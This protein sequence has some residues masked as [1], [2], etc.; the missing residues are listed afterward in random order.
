MGFPFFPLGL[1]VL[2]EIAMSDERRSRD[3]ILADLERLS[4]GSSSLRG[5]NP[6]S[7]YSSPSSAGSNQNNRPYS[8]NRMNRSEADDFGPAGFWRRLV[9][10]SIDSSI[11]AALSFFVVFPLALQAPVL[12]LIL[13]GA[14]LQGV[15]LGFAL[16]LGSVMLY[17]LIV[18]GCDRMLGSTPGKLLVGARVVDSEYSG[19]AS[20]WQF[21]FRET[22]GK[23]LSG[24]F[25]CL[26]YLMV[27]L[28][29]DK[30][31]LHDLLFSTR[32]KQTVPELGPVRW[33]IGICL[34]SGSLILA[35]MDYDSTRSALKEVDL[36]P[37]TSFELRRI[38]QSSDARGVIVSF[39]GPYCGPCRKQ[40]PRLLQ[41]RKD[42]A[43][44]GLDVIFVGVEGDSDKSEM[45]RFLSR[46]NVDFKTYFRDE[47][48]DEF[49]RGT[50]AA[51]SGA[52]PFT[53]VYDSSRK[54][55]YEGAGS[56]SDQQ[57]ESLIGQ[58]IETD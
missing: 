25:L 30:L 6:H 40:F 31:A 3:E 51:W 16:A 39:W 10:M 35:A 50:S 43:D 5:G 22:L 34:V 2:G 33:G 38:V 44:R 18:F 57:L 29:D 14:A 56:L 45:A 37:V 52:I 49:I 53:M 48:S 28:R 41:L 12:M 55:I 27:A 8:S 4:R 17:A 13:A 24:L 26:G 19:P 9:A 58:A 54:V 7:P 21:L 11:F 32:V 42:Y 36:Q 47:K 46:R 1:L 20:Y 15:I 23:V